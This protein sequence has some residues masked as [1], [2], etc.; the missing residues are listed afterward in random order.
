MPILQPQPAFYPPTLLSRTP[1][2]D[3]ELEITEDCGGARTWWAIYTRTRQEKALARK[4]YSYKVPF[5]LPMVPH[6]HVYR[7]RKVRSYIPLFSNYMFMLGT[8]EERVIALTTNS[9]SRMLPVTDKEQLFHDL[10]SLHQ[11]IDNGAPMTVEQRL[12]PGRAVRIKAGSLK[13]VEGIVVERRSGKRLLVAVNYIQQGISMA[14]ED[15]ML[16][17]I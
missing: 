9:V 16:E 15:F 4:L 5:Y 7:G 6:E 14:I 17:P 8:E 1:D 10:L 2:A 3:V 12:Q 11:L 13:G